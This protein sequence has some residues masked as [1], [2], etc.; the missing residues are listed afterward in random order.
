MSAETGML[1]MVV[2]VLQLVPI[3]S[4]RYVGVPHYAPL[5][6][7][8]AIR[9]E[10]VTAGVTTNLMTG[11]VYMG[12]NGMGIVYGREAFEEWCGGSDADRNTVPVAVC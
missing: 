3:N 5:P 2:V 12:D 11:F 10:G 6:P 4:P 8:P 1:I 7:W 9:G